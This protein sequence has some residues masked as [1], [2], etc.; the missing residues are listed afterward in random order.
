MKIVQ[1]IFVPGSKWFYIKLYAGVKSADSVLIKDVNF[2]IKELEKKEVIDKWFFVRYSDPEFHLRLRV[3]MKD[4][5]DMG[6]VMRLFYQRLG[7]SVRHTLIWKIQLDTYSRELERYGGCSME[8]TE[9]VF[10]TDSECELA[11]IRKIYNLKD[12]NYRWM[13]ALELID[14]LLSDFR[15]DIFDK[16]KLMSDLNNSFKAEYGFNKNNVKQFNSRFREHKGIV[17]SVLDHTITEPDFVSLYPYIR[18][19]TKKLIPIVRNLYMNIEKEHISI[20]SLLSS[21]I[22]MSLNRLFRSKNRLHELILYDYL[23]RYYTSKI[24]QREKK[25]NFYI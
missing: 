2:I 13:I 8:D 10:Y 25:V 4:E 21:Y 6:D 9:S 17:E 23:Y 5:D 18:R 3:L 15:F 1:R 7:Y 11:I 19:R 24:V 22:H 14:S 16:Q 20:N 12:E